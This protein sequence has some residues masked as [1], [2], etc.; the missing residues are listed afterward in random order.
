MRYLKNTPPTI[1]NSG[2]YIPNVSSTNHD[3]Q[4]KQ[5]QAKEAL[6]RNSYTPPAM[7]NTGSS[8]SSLLSHKDDQ[9]R[10]HS[11]NPLASSKAN[12]DSKRNLNTADQQNQDSHRHN[13]IPP[14]TTTSGSKRNVQSQKEADVVSGQNSKYNMSSSKNKIDVGSRRALFNATGNNSD[15]GVV[16]NTSTRTWKKPTVETPKE[17]EQPPVVA[18][19][20]PPPPPPPPTPKEKT[21][22]AEEKAAVLKLQ[23]FVRGAL[24][25][26][27]VSAMILK[28]IEELMAAE[29]QEDGA[30]A[31]E[32]E[33][34]LRRKSLIKNN[35][36]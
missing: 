34:Q 7:K 6:H 3:Y 22:T 17:P 26:A 1:G 12:L 30:A 20:T 27:R 10:R 11:Y 14:I 2:S 16:K 35:D 8:K 4:M 25:R 32:E 13:Y 31:E 9:T 23:C 29:Q 28:L 19:S 36:L 18:R 21:Y 5:K 15:S 33:N 24:C